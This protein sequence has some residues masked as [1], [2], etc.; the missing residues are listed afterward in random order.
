MNL[1]WRFV[2]YYHTSTKRQDLGI[3]AQ[4]TAVALYLNG[5]G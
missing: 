4:K 5:G 1:A 2:A 3:D